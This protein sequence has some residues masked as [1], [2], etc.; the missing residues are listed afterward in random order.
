MLEKVLGVS[1][2][3]RCIYFAAKPPH[4]GVDVDGLAYP[5]HRPMACSHQ[6]RGQ[7]L[8]PNAVLSHCCSGLWCLSRGCEAPRLGYLV[9]Y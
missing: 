4:V 8:L 5:L 9:E 1:V 7:C 2:V 3:R 6:T